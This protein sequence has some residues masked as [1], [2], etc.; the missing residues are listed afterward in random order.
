MVA[1][2]TAEAKPLMRVPE[3]ADLFDVEPETVRVW[4]RACSG[5]RWSVMPTRCCRCRVPRDARSCVMRRSDAWKRLR[6]SV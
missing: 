5:I 4:V 1:D 2:F 6:A 3:V